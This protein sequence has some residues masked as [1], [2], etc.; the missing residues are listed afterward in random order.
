LRADHQRPRA[1]LHR[2][3]PRGRL[4][5]GGARE[6]RNVLRRLRR[7]QHDHRDR[8]P[9]R[10]APGQRPVHGF[11]DGR[12]LPRG[13]FRAV[14]NG[15]G[16]LDEQPGAAARTRKVADS[17]GRKGGPEARRVSALDSAPGTR[18]PSRASGAPA[19]E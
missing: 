6:G 17:D 19:T 10:P 7:T 18:P 3:T 14:R 11:G 2:H 12:G 1:R 16:S 8:R 4:R 13:E 9:F 15:R 5:R